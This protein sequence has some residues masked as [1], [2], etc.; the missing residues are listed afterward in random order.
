MR[1]RGCR[2]VPSA[3][4]VRSISPFA[5][6]TLTLQVKDSDDDDSPQLRR[7]APAAGSNAPN[8]EECKQQ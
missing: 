5:P 8:A 2:C 3:N 4:P 1:G 7:H 6:P